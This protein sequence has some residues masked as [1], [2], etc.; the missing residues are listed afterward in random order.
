MEGKIH[1]YITMSAVDGPGLRFVLFL[2]GCPLRC[3]YCHNPDS[4][5]EDAGYLMCVQ[6]IM[7]LV[8]EYEEFYITSG[9]GLTITGGEPLFQT[10]FLEELLREAKAR[11]VSVAIDTSGYKDFS[12]IPEIISLAD[13]VILDVK[14]I[15]KDEYEAITNHNSWYGVA[16]AQFLATQSRPFWLRYVVLPTINDSPSHIQAFASLINELL[17]IHNN[18]LERIHI[19]PYSKLGIHKWKEMNLP[20]PLVDIEEP[21]PESLANFKSLLISKIASKLKKDFIV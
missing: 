3:V 9:G 4:W 21:S 20:E 5:A 17:A 7:D 12:T 1:S 10:N 8:L 2:Q 14:A 6:K 13:L 11:G 16:N 18:A 19:V 15:L